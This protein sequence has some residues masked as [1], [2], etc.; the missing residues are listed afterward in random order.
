MFKKVLFVAI[1]TFCCVSPAFAQLDTVKSV[2]ARYPTPLGNQHA[3]FLIDIACTTGKGLLRK[4]W[5]T[6]V[7]LP[8]G[9]GVSQDI[10]MERNGLHYDILGDGEGA[11][12]PRFDLVTEPPHVDPTRYYA[13]SCG[14]PPAPP[15][16]PD[17]KPLVDYSDVVARLHA[18]EQA[19]IAIRTATEET[20]DLL[21][22]LL[23][24][25]FPTYRGRNRYLGDFSLTPDP[26]R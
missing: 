13:P 17:S 7:R 9:T 23:A 26:A 15:T 19:T 5:G 1:A 4:D 21:R 22:E 18:L 2:R 11:A 6:F 25:P 10:L 3:A 20:R 8:D 12:V 24:K 14:A 16:I